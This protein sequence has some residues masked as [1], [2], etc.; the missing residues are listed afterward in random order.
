MSAAEKARKRK[1]TISRS[2]NRMGQTQRRRL[3][4]DELAK[5]E[6]RPPPVHARPGKGAGS[7]SGSG[8]GGVRNASDGRGGGWQ[9]AA[10]GGGGGSGG[11]GGGSAEANKLHPSWEASQQANTKGSIQQFEGKRVT[12]D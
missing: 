1:N 12:F 7:G 9:Q 2:G 10:P 4:E 5:K 8:R 6:G 11:G 3:A